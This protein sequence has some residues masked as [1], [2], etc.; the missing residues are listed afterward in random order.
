MKGIEAT[1]ANLRKVEEKLRKKTLKKAADKGGR[2]VWAAMKTIVPVDTATLKKSLGRKTKGYKTAAVS[3]I[4]ARVGFRGFYF[5]PH[6]K[7]AV[8]LDPV[9]YEHLVEFHPNDTGFMRAAVE[10]T[11][12]AVVETMAQTIADAL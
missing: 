3:I 9:K 2:V 11:K 10:E 7:R 6:R 1:L 12:T 5:S 4:G 8:L